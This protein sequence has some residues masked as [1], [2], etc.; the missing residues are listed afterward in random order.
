MRALDRAS[1]GDRIT[2]LSPRSRH[3]R[4]PCRRGVVGVDRLAADCRALRRAA[5]ADRLAGGG[6]EPRHR[7]V[8]DRRRRWRGSPRSM[9]STNLDAL[10]RYPLL[11]A[12]QAELWREAGDVDRA[13]AVLSRRPGPGALG[14]RATLADRQAF[15]SRIIDGLVEYLIKQY[16]LEPGALGNPVHRGILRRVSSPQ[17][18]RRDH[19]APARSRVADPD[20]RSAAAGRSHRRAGAGVVQDRPRD[21]RRRI[22]AEAARPGRRASTAPSTSTAGASCISGSAARAATGAARATSAR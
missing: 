5:G 9:R 1:A 16:A 21:P 14:A 2:R 8:A 15:A 20:G 4:L 7:R 17:D 10:D 6:A 13:V 12:I 22:D 18:R 3:R 19:H 11:P